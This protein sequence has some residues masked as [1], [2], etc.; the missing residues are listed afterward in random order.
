[1]TSAFCH[2]NGIDGRLDN[3]RQQRVDCVDKL[4][5]VFLDLLNPAKKESALSILTAM[6]AKSHWVVLVDRSLSGH[7][8]ESDLRR[9]VLV[10]R[11][12]KE[13]G[14]SPPKIV[15]LC[16]VLTSQADRT[17]KDLIQELQ[18]DGVSCHSAVFFDDRH[19]IT[20]PETTLILDPDLRSSALD[21][22]QWFA[23]RFLKPDPK[24]D[25]M[26]KRSGDDLAFGYRGCGLT[27]V[28]YSNCPTDSLPI[29]WYAN[30]SSEGY[31][32]VGPYVRVHSRIGN[33]TAEP[34]S[35]KWATIEGSADIIDTLRP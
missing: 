8:L 1:M 2:V 27:L 26:R 28:D 34:S 3:Q 6:L 25:R 16:Q 30:D 18:A 13:A 23:D 9:L 24:L 12:V 19:S 17:I 22:C 29:F 11:I 10:G 21:L 33:Q 20:H 7:S 35:V 4:A 5:D 32:Y 31:M 14:F 15:I